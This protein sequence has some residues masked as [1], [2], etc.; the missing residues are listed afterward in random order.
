MSLTPRAA[1]AIPCLFVVFLLGA[2]IVGASLNSRTG[3]YVH[4]VI[5]HHPSHHRS[6]QPSTKGR[7]NNPTLLPMEDYQDVLSTRHSDSITS[8]LLPDWPLLLLLVCHS[9]TASPQC[10]KDVP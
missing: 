7:H 4:A 2:G 1:R 5:L 9:R 3:R 6:Y 10:L 8:T